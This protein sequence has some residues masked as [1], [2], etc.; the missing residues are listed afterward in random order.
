MLQTIFNYA[1]II[2][3]LLSSA[4]L[5]WQFSNVPKGIKELRTQIVIALV[6]NLILF[7]LGLIIFFK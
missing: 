7:S 1:I 6:V 4:H 3:L 5:I 2:Y